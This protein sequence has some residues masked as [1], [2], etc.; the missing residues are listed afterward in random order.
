MTTPGAAPSLTVGD[1]EKA[2]NHA[3]RRRL[4]RPGGMSPG[5][6]AAILAAQHAIEHDV[7]QTVAEELD[8]PQQILYQIGKQAP[9]IVTLAANRCRA[10]G[11]GRCV[12]RRPRQRQH[13]M[14]TRFEG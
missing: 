1:A 13:C 4:E 3:R 6:V 5:D 14:E 11:I 8:L 2:R 12:R 10:S 9:E 7:V